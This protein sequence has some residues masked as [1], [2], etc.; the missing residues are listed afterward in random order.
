MLIILFLVSHSNFLFVLCGRLSWLPVSFLLHVKY[1]LSYRIVVS[2]QLYCTPIMIMVSLWIQYMTGFMCWGLLAS[3]CDIDAIH[4]PCV[5][6]SFSLTYQLLSLIKLLLIHHYTSSLS[7]L[8]DYSITA[9]SV[10]LK[11]FD[12]YD[13]ETNEVAIDLAFSL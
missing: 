12:W 13:S 9:T 1:T 10:L 2:R 7:L 6:Q 11:A 3:A 5:T 8:L 4:P